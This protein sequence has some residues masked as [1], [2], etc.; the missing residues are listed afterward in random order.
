ME[1]EPQSMNEVAVLMRQSFPAGISPSEFGERMGWGRG[2]DQAIERMNS[3]TVEELNA[4]GYQRSSDTMGHGLR[5]GR[6]LDAQ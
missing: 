4:I 6:P 5:G 1:N 2:S 3:I